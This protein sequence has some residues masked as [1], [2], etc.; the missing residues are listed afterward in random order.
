[1][2]L[3]LASDRASAAVDW[4]L[5]LPGSWDP[6]SPK[7]D[8]AKAAR[9]TQ[10]GIPA[11]A[12]HVEK[13]QL[14]LDMIDETRSWGIDV[15]LAVPHALAV[16]DADGGYGDAAAFRQGLEE[17]G[18]D[19]VVGISTTTSAQPE[20]A[21]PHTLPYGGHGPPPPTRLP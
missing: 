10:C 4:R 6:A 16:A 20:A 9:R 8:A 5:F 19:Y 15:P 13:W 3:H 7:T 14:A 18:L 21:R 11:E 1:V 12:G 2:S 17:R